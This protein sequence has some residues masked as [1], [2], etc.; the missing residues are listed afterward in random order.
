MQPAYCMLFIFF[1]QICLFF[2]WIVQVIGE[3]KA[4]SSIQMIYCDL[5]A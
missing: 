1:P 4:G 2:N 3:I 5:I